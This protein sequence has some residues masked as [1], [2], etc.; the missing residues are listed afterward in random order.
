M[1][2]SQKKY[3]EELSPV[4]CVPFTGKPL[5]YE[6][7]F[8]NANPVTVEIGFGMGAATAEIAAKNPDTNYNESAA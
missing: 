2:G 1:T 8:G 3:Y 4:W 5:S 7:V 6:T